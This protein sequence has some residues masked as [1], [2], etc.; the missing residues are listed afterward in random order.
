VLATARDGFIHGQGEQGL[1]V[2]QTRLVSI[3]RYRI[4]GKAPEP[5]G[6]SNLEADTQIAYYVLESPSANEDLFRGALG[7]GGRAATEAIELRLFRSV[8]D[9]LSE[10]IELRNHTQ[11]DAALTL[12]L[13]IDCDFADPSEVHGKRQQHGTIERSW[14]IGMNHAELAWAYTAEH[15]FD[16]QGHTGNAVLHRS[17]VVTF[18]PPA[19]PP[20]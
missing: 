14:R 11:Q 6:I 4:N 10:E 13:E 12:E 2:C 9:G 5:V 20:D 3:Y 8:G 7:P 16:H 17:A 18:S 1:F 15:S 19:G